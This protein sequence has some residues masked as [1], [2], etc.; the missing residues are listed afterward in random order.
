[1]SPMRTKTP[2]RARGAQAAGRTYQR[3]VREVMAMLT[4]REVGIAVGVGERTVQN[5]AA[6]ATR[7]QGDARDALLDLHYA[8]EALSDVYTPEGVETILHGR[9]KALGGRRPLE[10][11]AAGEREAVV[12]LAASRRDY[13]G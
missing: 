10:V 6:G 12:E 9:S 3:I 11:F 7:P 4:A 13:S 5:W 8:I 2:S 1:M